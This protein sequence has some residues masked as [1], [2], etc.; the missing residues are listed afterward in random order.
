MNL[1]GAEEK[2][3]KTQEELEKELK[4]LKG[5][6]EMGSDVDSFDEETDEAEEYSTNL[7]IKQ[8]LKERLIAVREALDKIKSGTYGK[9]EKCNKEISDK[10]L[11]INPESKYCGNCKAT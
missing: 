10:I 9:C 6:P 11:E 7:G 8:V 5:V 1:K 2:L 3:K 4:T